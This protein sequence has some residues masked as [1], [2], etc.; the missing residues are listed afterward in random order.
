MAAVSDDELI[1]FYRARLHED[2]AAARRAAS[3]AGPDW[4]YEQTVTADG[5]TTMLYGRDDFALADTLPRSDEEVAPFIERF[6][7]GRVLR[8]VEAGRKLITNYEEASETLD[9]QTAQ[10][11]PGAMPDVIETEDMTAI[12]VDAI[13]R[14]TQAPGLPVAAALRHEVAQRAAVYSDH[15]DYRH[16]WAP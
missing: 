13:G 10:R 2:E 4:R 6:D 11:E 12:S 1:E 3:E 16:E 14:Y 5:G 15:P 8:D 7:P 9:E